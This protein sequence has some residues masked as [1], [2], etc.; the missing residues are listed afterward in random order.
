[1]IV[2]K[3]IGNV[4]GFTTGTLT[5]GVER[6]F[7]A[8]KKAT[9][10]EVE[11]ALDNLVKSKP[12]DTDISFYSFFS[13]FNHVDLNGMDIAVAS[14]TLEDKGRLYTREDCVEAYKNGA[15]CLCI[16]KAITNPYKM[17]ERFVNAVNDYCKGN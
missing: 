11:V 13:L 10:K 14:K 12:L 6:F 9:P 2:Q 15:N 4:N 3:V 8:S 17:T 5:R 7:V 16:G 1:M